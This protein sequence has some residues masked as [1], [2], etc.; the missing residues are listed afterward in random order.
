MTGLQIWGPASYG[1]AVAA[2]IA[3]RLAPVRRG[4]P[5]GLARLAA[6]AVA[7]AGGAA[8]STLWLGGVAALAWLAG[9]AS[10]SAL[11]TGL[12]FTR[13]ERSTV[14]EYGGRR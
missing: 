11:A 2:A 10:V 3:W 7:F 8:L 6:W 9:G 1:A 12:L 13:V 4:R 5:A 14:L